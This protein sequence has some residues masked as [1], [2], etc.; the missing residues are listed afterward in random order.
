MPR[1]SAGGRLPHGPRH[2]A[3]LL[4][5]AVAGCGVLALTAACSTPPPRALPPAPTSARPAPT[6]TAPPRA[7]RPPA[8]V[9][10]PAATV[11]R[12]PAP[13]TST[14]TAPPPP[15]RVPAAGAR[16]L[17]GVLTRVA[18][19][20]PHSSVD[21][22]TRG[23]VLAYVR[24]RSGPV[25]VPAPDVEHLTTGSSVV[26]DVAAGRLL[27]AGT[28]AQ[29]R[30]VARTAAPT[31]PR[32]AVHDVVAVLV[33][34]PGARPD[35][36]TAAGLEAAVD[37]PVSQY[38]STQTGGRVSF[39]VSRAVGWTR[40]RSTCDDA[41]SLWAEVAGRVGFVPGPRR[42][43]VVLVPPS[44]PGCYAGLGTIGAGPEEGGY[45]YVRGTLPGLVAH[46]LGHNLGLGHSNGLQCPDAADGRF[47]S[48]GW[49]PACTRSAYRDWYDVMGVSW[50]RLGTLSTAQAYRLGVLGPGDVTTVTGP[51]RVT[52]TAVGLH[53]GVRAL[54]V[55]TPSGVV[56]TVEYRPAAGDDAWLADNW[57][58]LR[59]G[60][61]VR[62]DD[63]DGGAGQTLL[64]DASPS[65]ASDMAADW[66]EALTP[67]G[68]LTLAGGSIVIRLEDETPTTAQVAGQVG[69]RLPA[70][71]D[72]DLTRLGTRIADGDS[73]QVLP[74]PAGTVPAPS[75]RTPERGRGPVHTPG[76]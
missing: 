75:R 26:A 15:P 18:V 30:S 41:W 72:G 2:V 65:G 8:V 20:S 16:R 74:T 54:R 57:R 23:D 62:R 60:V 37:G 69:G 70:S 28:T 46:E 6:L 24:T 53:A 12:S 52:L 9:P 63:P 3:G 19:E 61:L 43:L 49:T 39:R 25:E 17:R 5:S 38:W 27:A 58:G 67:G 44:L 42:H 14:S 29:G 33:L 76:R 50:D 73:T 1:S 40:V 45:S 4:A 71:G 68:G 11:R 48:G 13:A 7:S 56:Y 47:S 36:T 31:P 10:R 32:R 64:L 21:T 22:Q 55:R 51:A 59:P 66:D 34:P 35:A